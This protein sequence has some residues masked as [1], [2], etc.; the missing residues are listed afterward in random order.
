MGENP[1]PTPILLKRIIL[2]LERRKVWLRKKDRTTN[3][4]ERKSFAHI[5]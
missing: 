4:I 1:S 5:G 2:L 3:I